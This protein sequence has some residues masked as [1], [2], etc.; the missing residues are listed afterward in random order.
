MLSKEYKGT[1]ELIRHATLPHF[2]P[3][4][5][6]LSH[7]AAHLKAPQ[8]TAKIKAFKRSAILPPNRLQ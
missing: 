6:W 5:F 2:S 4:A 1:L 8:A 3:K 7:I